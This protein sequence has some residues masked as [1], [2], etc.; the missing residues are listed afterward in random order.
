MVLLITRGEL[1]PESDRWNF[2]IFSV[3]IYVVSVAYSVLVT[4]VCFVSGAAEALNA[5]LKTNNFVPDSTIIPDNKS[6]HE[7]YDL[8]HERFWHRNGPCVDLRGAEALL[9]AG[10]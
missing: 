8:G 6:H 2:G 9:S 10:Q 4:I 7:L 1:L 3:P 5:S